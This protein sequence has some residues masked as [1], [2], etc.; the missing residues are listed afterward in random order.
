MHGTVT[1]HIV[2][3]SI[4]ILIQLYLYG[5]QVWQVCLMITVA[6][7]IMLF[8]PRKQQQYYVMTWCL[9]CLSY[10]H[11]YRMLYNFGSYQLTVSTYTM[12]LVC[13]L[14]ALSWCYH[15]GA[16]HPSELTQD[17]IVRKVNDLPSVLE[18]VSY[19]WFSQTSGLGVF[20]EF[21][22]YKRFIERTAEY[23]KVPSPI[24]ASICQLAIGLCCLAVYT[25]FGAYFPIAG[26]WSK[27]YAEEYSFAYKY[28]YFFLAMT[29]QRYFYYTPFSFSQGNIVASGFGYNGTKTELDGVEEHEKKHRWD[30]IV[31]VYIK[32][33]ETSPSCIEHLRYWNHQV[34]LWLKF[35]IQG[36]IVPKGTRATFGHTLVVFLTSA[37]WHG[38]Y[39][40]YYVMF[41]FAAILSEI[42]KDVFKVRKAI[43]FV[44]DSAKNIVAGFF[45]FSV[46]NYMGIIFTSLTFENMGVFLKATYGFVPIGLIAALLFS[47]TTGIVKRVQ[48]A[49]ARK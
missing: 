30:K 31:T 38:F 4:G 20:F 44:P 3:S 33:L 5:T 27:E 34:H 21:S 16:L 12:L 7:L 17:Q 40:V 45:T 28:L 15:D 32:L 1:R 35:Y 47:R 37:Y 24:S 9:I 13:K 10:T 29:G 25:V 18:M 8:F 48:K 22:D 2:T 49:E 43:W 26:C 19:T 6:Y 42:T 46:M 41:F 23:K 39:P 14:N 36:R 11:L